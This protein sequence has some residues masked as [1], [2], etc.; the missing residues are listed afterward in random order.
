MLA[1][2]VFTIHLLGQVVS[3]A[4]S[5][6]CGLSVIVEKV[7]NKTILSHDTQGKKNGT[8]DDLNSKILIN[9]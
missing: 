6:K 1:K 4:G 9:K 3:R 5:F 7:L 8:E 2:K